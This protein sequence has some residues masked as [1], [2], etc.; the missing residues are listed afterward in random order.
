VRE[1]TIEFKKL[2]MMLGI[3]PKNLDVLLKYPGGLH[4]HLRKQVIFF[5]PRTVDEACVQEQFL[6]NI[7]HKKGSQ[8]VPSIKSTRKLPRRGRRS[9]KGE[10][11]RIWNPLHINAR[12]PATIVTIAVLMRTL[13]ENVGNYIQN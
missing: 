5:K 13:R 11:I 6:E 10:R 3:S 1:Y 9:G 2:A 7:G 4:S 12:I 8:T